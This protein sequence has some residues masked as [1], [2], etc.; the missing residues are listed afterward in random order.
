[1]AMLGTSLDILGRM[2][3]IT[4]EERKKMFSEYS[5]VPDI[6]GTL[7]PIKAKEE[8]YENSVPC[9]SMV[10]KLRYAKDRKII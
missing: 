10:E 5:F 4:V 8:R 7:C 6:E 2:V 3:D 1:M 9:R